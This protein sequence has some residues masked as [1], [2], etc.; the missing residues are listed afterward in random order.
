MEQNT[1]TGGWAAWNFSATPDAKEVFN[2]TL[3]KLIGVQYSQVA[4]TTQLVNG[5]NYAF[6]CE[7]VSATFPSNQYLVKALVHKPLKGN[8]HITSIKSVGPVPNHLPGGW[9]NWD[10]TLTAGAKAVFNDAIKQIYGVNYKPLA[11]TTQLVNGTN[12]CFLCEAIAAVEEPS[13]YPALVY[14]HQAP[15]GSPHIIGIEVIHPNN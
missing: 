12:S 8:P 5:T 10:F 2:E 15:N 6:L 7:A 14:I 1:L 3:G 13:S 4:F 11:D 9:Q